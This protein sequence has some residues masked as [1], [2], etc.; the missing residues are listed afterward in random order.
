MKHLKSLIVLLVALMTGANGS[1]WA[2]VDDTFTVATTEGVSVTYKV[3]TESGSTGTVQVGVGQSDTPAVPKTTEGTVTIPE[4]VTYRSK[5]YAVTSIAKSG[6]YGCMKLSYIN[7]PNTLTKIEWIAFGNCTLKSLHIPASVTEIGARAFYSCPY[8]DEITVDPANTVYDSRN[9]CNAVIEKETYKLII[10]SNHTVVPSDV[11]I[12]GE[13]AFGSRSGLNSIV[14]PE[15][16]TTLEEGAFIGCS[17]MKFVTLPSTVTSIG[18]NAFERCI[19]ITSINIPSSVNEI[20]NYAFSHCNNLR[21]VTCNRTT[22][23]TLGTQC[24]DDLYSNAKLYVP[25]GSVNAYQSWSSTFPRILAIGTPSFAVDD[26]ITT[27]NSDGLTLI[28]KITDMDTPAVEL[29]AYGYNSTA[30][31]TVEIPETITSNNVTFTVTAIQGECFYW[32]QRITSVTIPS[33]VSEIGNSAFYNCSNLEEVTCYCSEPPVLAYGNFYNVPILWVPE[34]CVEKYQNNQDWSR[35]FEKI[36]V[37]GDYSLYPGDTFT[38]ELSNG[39]ILE[40]DVLSSNTVAV[41]SYTYNST[42]NVSLDIPETVTYNDVTYTVKEIY[43]ECFSGFN[44]LTAVTIPSTVTEIESYAFKDCEQLTSISIPSSLTNI[45]FN[46][47]D[48]TGWYNSQPDGMVYVGSVAYRY[49]GNNMSSITSFEV[50]AGTK[51]IAS[52]AF[53]GCAN[54][55]TLTIPSS[56]TFIGDN[57][58]DEYCYLTSVTCYATTPPVLDDGALYA[59]SGNPYL[60]LPNE[61]YIS[62]YQKSDWSY[63]F[64]KIRIIGDTSFGVGDTFTAANDEGVNV[65]YL[66]TSVDSNA[67]TGTAKTY[68]YWNSAEQFAVTA[69]PNDYQGP[70]TIPATATHEGITYTVTEIGSES[71]DAYHTNLLLTEVTLPSTITAIGDYAFDCTSITK[72]TVLATEPPQLSED[73]LYVADGAIL[74]VPDVPEGCKSDYES[75][76]WANFFS[77]IKVIGDESLS[78]GESF[79]QTLQDSKN[80]DLSVDLTY[81]ITA[82]PEGNQHGKV[83]IGT[84]NGWACGN[85]AMAVFN[86]IIPETVTYQNKTYDVIRIGDGAFYGFAATLEDGITKVGLRS[87]SIPAT[88]TSIGEGAFYNCSILTGVVSYATQPPALGDYAFSDIDIYSLLRV[89]EGSGTS[90]ENS[91]W[92]NYFTDIV[93]IVGSH[94]KIAG[95]TIAEGIPYNNQNGVTV[96]WNPDYQFPIITLNNVNLTYDAGPAIEINTYDRVDIYLVGDNTVSSTL[97]NCAAISIGTEDG[98]DAEGCAIMIGKVSEDYNYQ[99]IDFEPASLTIPANTNIGIYCHDSNIRMYDLTAHIAGL[100]YG[101]FTN[102]TFQRGEVMSNRPKRSQGT[103][104]ALFG[105]AESMDIEL[106]GQT[107]AFMAKT[108][109]DYGLFDYYNKLLA[110]MPTGAV[111]ELGQCGEGDDEYEIMASF[112]VGDTPATSLHF[113]HEYFVRYTTEGVPMKFKILDEEKKTCQVYG[114][115]GDDWVMISSIPNYY[116]GPI[117]IPETVDFDDETYTVTQIA[118]YAFCNC[119]IISAVIPASVT[120]IENYAFQNCSH[121]QAIAC[122]PT[123]PPMIGTAESTHSDK[124]VDVY[125]PYGCK[126]RYLAQTD[127]WKKFSYVRD[128]LML[129]KGQ[130]NITTIEAEDDFITA[131]FM[132]MTDEYGVALDLEDAVAGGVYYNLKSENGEGYDTEEQ[133]IVINNTI[134]ETAMEAIV[135]QGFDNA[136]HQTIAEQFSGLIMQ[137]NGKGT[138]EIVCKT[139]GTGQLSVR[140]GNGDPIPYTTQDES[141]TIN[142]NFDVDEPTCIYIYASAVANEPEPANANGYQMEGM[143]RTRSVDDNGVKIYQLSVKPYVKFGDANDDNEVTVLDVMLAANKVLGKTITTTFN[144]KNADINGDGLF[145]VTDVMGIVKI[146]FGF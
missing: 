46:A 141:A 78:P 54:L 30:P 84:N 1:V 24:F 42:D 22:P 102:G 126:K 140:I 2:A 90:Y 132:D 131:Y 95:E 130:T 110:W 66:I 75:S 111:P 106:T 121:L 123:T 65:T 51:G 85:P 125:V 103:D 59:P 10:G 133:C 61:D 58:F 138:V 143:R 18:Q 96:T 86:L 104:M 118:N 41:K 67:N 25:E 98:A 13:A 32:F 33:S 115:Y 89:P 40:Y 128:I 47:F 92:R 145:T 114:N 129:D 50:A 93:E 36:R 11:K 35:G 39:M 26:V 27:T 19:R 5:T 83:Q 56:V 124:S 101:I 12:I 135:S 116:R 48:G 44:K 69:V 139:L 77:V 63:Y 113:G 112:L 120:S 14:L 134:S 9:D 31:V 57:I 16:V 43:Y 71:F 87:I 136:S 88:V 55:T 7:L 4:S 53:I 108:R 21:E 17:E 144:E 70:L 80:D 99:P 37:I 109:S 142:V 49:K 6:F 74:Y 15:G 64:N 122:L 60:F 82:L 107:A 20:G 72:M 119:G 38:A 100:Q 62:D 105:L 45:G 91:A 52:G 146:V 34:G 97:P 68:G 81:M 73:A 76:D 28:Y 29:Y 23:P 117:T 137:V 8:L 79:V 3:L 127:G 94:I